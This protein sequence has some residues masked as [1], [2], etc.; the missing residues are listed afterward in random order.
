[1]SIAATIPDL[2]VPRHKHFIRAA[3][4]EAAGMLRKVPAEE[5]LRSK[6]GHDDAAVA[7][8]NRAN[9][10]AAM[11]TVPSWAGA[12][13][14]NSFSSF[15]TDLAPASAAARLI[16][17]GIKVDLTGFS[18]ITVPARNGPAVAAPWVGEGAGIPVV[19]ATLAAAVV[20]PARKL[21]SIVVWTEE[22][23][24]VSGAAAIFEQLLRD[25]V[26]AALDLAYFSA[27]A[28]SASAHAGLLNG[29]VAL[30][31][32]SAGGVAAAQSDLA[33]LAGAVS[34]P[35]SSGEVVFV[36]S[37]ANAAT[38]PL[39]LPQTQIT[40]LGTDA[41]TVGQVVAIDPKAIVHATDREPDVSAS[42]YVTLHMEDTSPVAM[43]PRTESAFQT[44]QIALRV[45]HDVAFAKRRPDA[46]AW[47]SAADWSSAP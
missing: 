22:L 46:V 15:V 40:V 39:A 44:G 32:S 31:P 12:L 25:N 14:S 16:E 8:L 6:W 9:P 27:T 35:G 29:V 47:I 5:I 3:Y 20:G 36:V 45:I 10:G 30:P 21:G 18:T 43:A 13:A 42:K 19:K 4:A 41:L 28:G 7:L 11:T 33:A 26:S 1:M 37:R 34:G 23:D 24:K 17:L 38:M 2:S